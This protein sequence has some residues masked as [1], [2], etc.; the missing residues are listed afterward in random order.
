MQTHPHKNTYCHQSETER[1]YSST[2]VY[3][4][5]IYNG[6][7]FTNNYRH[8]VHHALPQI[9]L[10]YYAHNI[11][12]DNVYLQVFA[13]HVHMRTMCAVQKYIKSN[14]GQVQYNNDIPCKRIV[15][16]HNLWHL[17]I[18]AHTYRCDSF[19]WCEIHF[20]KQLHVKLVQIIKNCNNSF[21]RTVQ[22][23]VNMLFFRLEGRIVNSH[24]TEFYFIN[25][26]LP[27]DLFQCCTLQ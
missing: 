12:I 14:K 21:Y 25:G 15:L 13:I 16:W 19:S 11:R 1:S 26:N 9:D 20:N 4:V 5:G 18:C 8:T 6:R 17:Q 27:N 3:V 10:L 23:G 7:T 22:L 24:R 2:E